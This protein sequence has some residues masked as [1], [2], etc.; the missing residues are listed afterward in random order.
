MTTLLCEPAAAP[1]ADNVIGNVVSWGRK[2][3]A[4][5]TNTIVALTLILFCPV[6]LFVNWNTLEEHD[7]S[8]QDAMATARDYSVEFARSLIPSITRNEAM[9]YAAWLLWQQAL[10]SYLPGKQCTGQLTPGGHALR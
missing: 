7:A 3:T 9:G 10:Y 8:F 1:I 5:R 2:S 4:D 6:L